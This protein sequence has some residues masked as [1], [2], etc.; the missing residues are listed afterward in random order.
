MAFGAAPRVSRPSSSAVDRD[1]DHARDPD[2]GDPPP[3]YQTSNTL[4]PTLDNIDAGK[5]IWTRECAVCH[6]DSGQGEGIYREGIEAIPP[7]FNDPG[8]YGPFLDADYFW[9]IS[10]GVPWTAMPTW[11]LV[12]NPTERWQVVT[13]IRTM[14]TK[15][16]PQPMQPTE[17]QKI[18]TT[19]V[20]KA[21]RL[22]KSASYDAGRQQFLV[23]CAH[24]HGLAGD[25]KG[26][27]AAF[28]SPA[29]A[30]LQTA[31]APTVPGIMDH[32]DGITFSKITNGMRDSAMPTWGEFLSSRMR[33]NDVKYVKDSYTVGVPVASNASHSGTGEVPLPYVRTD[34]GIFQAEIAT[35]V[36]SA[37]K[38]IYDKYCSTCH[39]AKGQGDGPGAAGLL[40]GH[41][42]PLAKNMAVP[43]IFAVTR[44]GIPNSHMYGF[45]P[46][47]SETDIWNVTAYIVRLTGGKWGG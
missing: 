2:E 30:N 7:N 8:H 1:E 3:S 34:S 19:P 44:G 15:T 33:W 45:Q 47:I 39:G 37:G 28:L 23:Q 6:G 4:Q 20:M 26:W 10:E 29:P 38:P 9:R 43:Y 12:Y 14:F 27:D 17:A 41:P 32:Y 22:P 42:A 24:C 11:K 18:T 40:G 25:G 46:V 16:T 5:R 36:P 21:L 31:V 35:I 13:F